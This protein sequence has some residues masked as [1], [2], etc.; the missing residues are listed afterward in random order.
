MKKNSLFLLLIF[1]YSFVFSQVNTQKSFHDT[2]GSIE[3]N[4]SGQ[5]QFSLP[6]ALPPAVKSIAPQ[7]NLVYTSG[8]GNG[9][10]G[11]GWNLS[12]I[13]VISRVGKN[14][15]KDGKTETINLDENDYFSFNGQRLILKSG[16]YGKDGAEYTTEKFS[17]VKIK[18]IGSLEGKKWKGP[19][20]WEVSFE[21]GS[22]AWYGAD[23]TSKTAIEYNITKW[24]DAQGNYI[25]YQYTLQNNVAVISRI[26]W[27]GNED[28]N[29][30]HFNQ[31][32]F[33][34]KTRDL[35]E[36]SYLAG[37]HF[38]QD[39]ILTEIVVRSNGQQ[40]KKYVIAY[41]NG[42]NGTKYQ[43]VKNITE[44]NSQNQPAN[45]I[46][47]EYEKT[48]NEAG[49]MYNDSRF[50]DVF[51]KDFFTGDFNGDGR[52]D[53]L[54][55]NRIILNRLDK[56]KEYIDVNYKGKI[57]AVGTGIKDEILLNRQVIFT[58][59]QKGDFMNI[60]TYSLERNQLK[61]LKTNT[62]NLSEFDLGEK[63]INDTWWEQFFYSSEISEVIE[64]DFNGNGLSELYLE[65]SR[66][67][68]YQYTD[69]DPNLDY[70]EE[71]IIAK[72]N[73][74]IDLQN[75]TIKELFF[76][77]D[78][79][80]DFE[81]NGKTDLFDMSNGNV[82]VY[83]Y[84]GDI[85][86]FEKIELNT[87]ISQIGL[88][89]GDFNG[90]GK[91]DF[92]TPVGHGSSDWRMYISTGKG[93]REY[94]YSNLFLYEPSWQGSPRKRRNKQRIYA[95]PDLNKD[96][97][98][99]FIIFESQRWYKDKWKDWN[100]PDSS[101]GF[102]Y[103][104]NNGVDRDGK[105]IFEL[106]YHINPIEMR[107]GRCETINYSGYGEHY[108]PIFG[109]FRIAQLNTDF[110]I[111]HKTKLITWNMGEDIGKSYIKSITQGGLKTEIEYKELDPEKN[112]NFYAGVNSEKYPYMELDKVAQSYAVSQLR[113]EIAPN[114]VRK[115][116]FRYRGF[117][118]HLQG[119]GMIG[120][121]KT[122]RSSWY[123]DGYENTKV[124]SG[125]EIDPLNEG[126]PIKEWSIK[127][128]N[129]SEVFPN[130][131]SFDNKKLL[132]FKETKY[133]IDNIQEG[134][135][136][137][138]VPIEVK[139]KDFIKDITSID[140][141]EYDEYYLP[142][143]TISNTQNGF[144]EKITELSYY[145]P[146]LTGE[147][148]DYSVGRPRSKTELVR[149]YGDSK[150]AKEEYEYE[151]NLLKTLKI[152][153]RDN[154][155]YIQESYQ[156]D[157]F[158]NIIEKTISNSIDNHTQ[159]S[160]SKYDAKGRFVIEKTDNLGLITKISYNNWGQ[161]LNQINPLDDTLHFTYDAWGK[162]LSQRTNLGGTTRYTY[163]KLDNGE[164]KITE[165]APD[166]GETITYTN[167]IGQNYKSITKSFGEKYVSKEV[168][169]DVLGRK[170]KESEPYFEGEGVSQWNTIEYD[171]YSRPIK[172][173]AFTGKIVET[174]YTGN[175]V[176]ITET[177]ANGRFKK[178]VFDP[179]GKYYFYGR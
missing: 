62:F 121:R 120:F 176:K 124:W 69:I 119:K 21:D 7:I 77:S 108:I 55:G 132:S 23:E 149:A 6:V 72:K 100:D 48:K 68:F 18:S 127:T 170:I 25:S 58:G 46:S 122:A 19:A 15:D 96:G 91:T 103:F 125:A 144:A 151:N 40:F 22:Q 87:N 145:P 28:L 160:K 16:E 139:T 78:F 70:H 153:N 93:F 85:G 73:F 82:K 137:A 71:R 1:T 105:P 81:G 84:N 75:N 33:N 143:K 76:R 102:H 114:Q 12:G 30:P 57:L 56:N 65:I 50:D 14:L 11:Y 133:Q 89:K 107:C 10:A 178:Q 101:Y 106:V 39:K 177:N 167:K 165:Y 112:P 45:P 152:Y 34:Y 150:G 2:Q 99:D 169:Y 172:A 74:Y 163:E 147:G 123:A 111:L 155:E 66:K 31:I 158:G 52:I 63:I 154:S 128:D 175:S 117:I 179:I 118:T 168:V 49:I 47:F 38:V 44:Y 5:L 161:V 171:E 83:S 51:G 164:A 13:T 67:E 115:Q 53:F 166:G 79:E 61:L 35:K 94:Y 37:E 173:T 42:T 26:D 110:I 41:D 24:R 32:I 141:V 88:L 104:R 4:G 20:H 95:S 174:E 131:I 135:I 148:K 90:D 29:K 64:G 109:N 140:K 43:F 162:I 156:Y 126:L 92:M 3:V 116:D 36:S 113:Q 27:G 138:I 8:S 59:E 159:T 97:K 54:R 130:Q 157:G 80:G 142:V 134:K 129:E 146:Q 136:K 9:I 60:Y 86:D 98:S 17:N